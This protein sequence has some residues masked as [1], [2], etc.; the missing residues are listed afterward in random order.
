MPGVVGNPPAGAQGVF[1]WF[2]MTAG[3]KKGGRGQP[4]LRLAAGGAL[5]LLN[6]LEVLKIA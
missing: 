3:V 2:G 4:N 6:R 1:H 5:R